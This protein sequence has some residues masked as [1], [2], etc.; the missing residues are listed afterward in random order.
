MISG[1][2][3]PLSNT[4]FEK[5]VKQ[6]LTEGKIHCWR[7]KMR[8][9]SVIKAFVLFLCVFR[10]APTAW[11]DKVADPVK[12]AQ[13]V[14]GDEALISKIE[15][16]KVTLQSLT[17]VSK[18]FTVS[19]SDTGKLKVG[20]KV[21]VQGNSVSKIEVASDSVKQSEGL[22]NTVPKPKDSEQPGAAPAP[23]TGTP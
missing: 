2:P 12:S 19:L 23:S 4:C 21:R 22:S 20:D 15:S 8:I 1:D 17:D 13:E 6:Q 10:F 3:A 9:S 18:E 11:A 16:E 14:L 7:Y 5:G